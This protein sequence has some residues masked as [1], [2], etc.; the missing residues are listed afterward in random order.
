[1]SYAELFRGKSQFDCV[2]DCAQPDCV[3]MHLHMLAH[4]NSAGLII[5]TRHQI[6]QACHRH[7]VIKLLEQSNH[8]LSN[9]TGMST[10]LLP[11][12]AIYI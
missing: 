11:R 6:S 5:T 2:P 7:T 3:H 4:I 1:M 10:N 12:V 9:F 8:A